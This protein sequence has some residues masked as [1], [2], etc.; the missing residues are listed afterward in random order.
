MHLTVKRF[1]K[2]N[3]WLKYVSDDVY[4]RFAFGIPKLLSSY[5]SIWFGVNT[6]IENIL[7]NIVGTVAIKWCADV[8]LVGFGQV[9]K[10]KYILSTRHGLR[11]WS[12][13]IDNVN[14][15]LRTRSRLKYFWILFDFHRLLGRTWEKQRTLE[16]WR[17][18]RRT[19]YPWIRKK[20]RTIALNS[21][22]C[23]S[24]SGFCLHTEIMVILYS[25]VCCN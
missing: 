14:K 5:M 3:V 22:R 19:R 24:N 11:P 16:P 13:G 7:E 8:N 21:Y 4:C 20:S 12:R 1:R 2:H 23:D 17:C 15:T 10:K 18:G 6:D 25:S 9:S